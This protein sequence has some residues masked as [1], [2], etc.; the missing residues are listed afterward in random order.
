LAD[1]HTM[2][3]LSPI[4]DPDVREPTSIRPLDAQVDVRHAGTIRPVPTAGRP[5]G[6][7]GHVR[8]HVAVVAARFNANVT[9]RLLAGAV[10]ALQ[11][12][13]ATHETFRVPGSFELPAAVRALVGTGR[14][15]AV[16]PIGCL[17]RGDTSHFQVIADA[18]AY[19]LMR[20]TLD[21]EVPVVFGVLTCDTLGQALDRAGGA[22]G[23]K[24]AEAARAALELVALRQAIS[25][26]RSSRASARRTR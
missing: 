22:E 16:V 3:R 9:D 23:D 1:A 18:V 6:R 25:S 17:I 19:G 8:A 11:D 20:V 10:S 21:A 26:E 13:G 15:D 14:F 24:G 2:L 12:A 5:R 7:G 4:A